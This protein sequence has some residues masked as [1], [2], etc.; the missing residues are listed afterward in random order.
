MPQVITIAGEQL[1]A[2]KAQANEALNIDKFIFAYVPGQDPTAPVDRNEGMPAP[3]H[4]VYEQ[5]VQKRGRIN[6]N[7]VVYSTVLDSVT[8]PFEF[9][10]VGLFSTVNNTVVAISH[11]LPVQK[12]VTV[13]GEAGNTLNRNFGIEYSGIADLEGITVSPET[14][15]LDYTA[16]LN[17]MDELTRQL[18]V[19]MN[20]KDWFIANGFK[21][22]PTATTNEFKVNAGTGYVGG[23]RVE[24]EEECILVLSGY[25]KFVYLDAWFTGTAESNWK[26]HFEIVVSGD[27]L[28]SYQDGEGKQHFLAKVAEITAANAVKDLRDKGEIQNLNQ[29][30]GAKVVGVINVSEIINNNPEFILPITPDL[31]THVTL[32]GHG[33]ANFTITGFGDAAP[34]GYVFSLLI[35]RTVANTGQTANSLGNFVQFMHTASGD[36]IDMTLNA[37][38]SGLS[39]LYTYQAY[40][41]ASDNSG[42]LCALYEQLTFTHVGAGRWRLVKLPEP[43]YG[44]VSDVEGVDRFA[45]GKQNLFA[46]KNSSTTVETL[47]GSTVYATLANTWTFQAQFTHRATVSVVEMTGV[48]GCWGSRASSGSPSNNEY[49]WQLLRFGAVASAPTA[50]LTA[51]GRWKPNV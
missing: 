15:Q 43:F 20:G 3:E 6:G 12:T 30:L 47:L 22:E 35:P 46:Q 42:N 14:W 4:I 38:Q 31:G 13:P 16:R 1:F 18:A 40:P 27:E 29:R 37:R 39:T 5:A 50:S 7:V 26:G 51:S 17:G 32:S 24:L 41:N 23:L 21:V 45:N 19:D 9:N 28:T 25:P 11:I 34:I 49:Q 8:G 48:G 33:G 10:W 2:L 36:G 44:S